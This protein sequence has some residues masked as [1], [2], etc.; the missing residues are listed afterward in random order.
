MEKHPVVQDL[1]TRF[2]PRLEGHAEAVRRD[3]PNVDIGVYCW[4]V[5][6]LTDHEGHDIGIDCLIAG[7]P[8]DRPD[9]VALTIEVMH[10]T[11]EPKI[12]GADVV[13]GH[14]SGTIEAEL[15]DSDPVPYSEA[16]IAAVEEGLDDLVAALREALKRGRPHDWPDG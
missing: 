3:F 11:T 1:E 15:F 9:N 14:P 12:F 6:S 5:G 10:L 16:N 7:V 13:W 4:S 2:L 8:N